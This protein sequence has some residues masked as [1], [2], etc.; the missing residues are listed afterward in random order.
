[1]A[2]CPSVVSF[3]SACALAGWIPVLPRRGAKVSSMLKYGGLLMADSALM[4]IAYNADKVLL[5]RFWGAQA[6]GFYGRA[7]SLV[8]IP[9]ANLNTAVSS[10]AFPAFTPLQPPPP[11]FPRYFFKFYTLFLTFIIPTT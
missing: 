1:M 5:G 2:I 11:R 4:Y 10:V 6:L 8:N 9:S 7:Y 3:I